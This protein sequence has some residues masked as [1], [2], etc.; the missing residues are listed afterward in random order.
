IPE[1]AGRVAQWADR[2]AGLTDADVAYRI[3]RADDGAGRW[4]ARR[5]ALERDPEGRPIRFVGAVRDITGHKSAE[6]RAEADR[7]ELRLIT[8]ALPVLIAFID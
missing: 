6:Q 2:G 4:I 5:G 7:R 8:D 1:D 3:R